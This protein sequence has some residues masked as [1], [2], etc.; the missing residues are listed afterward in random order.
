MKMNKKTLSLLFLYFIFQSIAFGEIKEKLFVCTD[1]NLYIC[2]ELIHIYAKIETTDTINT[3]QS[4][5]IYFELL[6]ST[7]NSII[8]TKLC[9]SNKMVD[10]CMMIPEDIPTGYYCLK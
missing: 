8:Q 1:R 5:I 4:K 9:T 7:G 10:H 6:N 3:N 2:G